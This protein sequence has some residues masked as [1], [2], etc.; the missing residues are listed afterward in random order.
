MTHPQ[1]RYP[2]GDPRLAEWNRNIER[3]IEAATGG[4]GDRLTVVEEEL[5]ALAETATIMADALVSIEQMT[6]TIATAAQVQTSILARIEAVSRGL[7][8]PHPDE[9]GDAL[10][11][12]ALNKDAP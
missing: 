5:M 10:I 12:A 2:V 6:V 3:A 11:S 4:L 7:P 8:D 1:I 9:E